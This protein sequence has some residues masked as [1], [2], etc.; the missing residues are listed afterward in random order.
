MLCRPK[1]SKKQ[2]FEEAAPPKSVKKAAPKTGCAAL[3]CQEKQ[4]KN[5]R[6]QAAPP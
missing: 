5:N 3:K 2:L 6:K 1:M 4:I